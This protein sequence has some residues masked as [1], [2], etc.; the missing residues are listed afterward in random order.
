MSRKAILKKKDS[1]GQL[2]DH[3]DLMKKE[4]GYT[5]SKIKSLEK[6]QKQSEWENIDYVDGKSISE[7]RYQ[8]TKLYEKISS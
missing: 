8:E 5:T 6:T 7:L 4:L 3:L 1:L 2:K